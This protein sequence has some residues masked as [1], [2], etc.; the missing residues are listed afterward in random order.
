MTLSCSPPWL[1]FCLGFFVFF[2]F[3]LLPF[4]FVDVKAPVQSTWYDENETHPALESALGLS[5]AQLLL[6]SSK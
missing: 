2:P 1:G 4:A 6:K 5:T 3:F